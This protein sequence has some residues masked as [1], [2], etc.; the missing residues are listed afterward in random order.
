M[1]WRASEAVAGG[2]AAAGRVA[3]R[4][5]ALSYWFHLSYLSQ[6]VSVSGI[7]Q[8][9]GCATAMWSAGSCVAVLLLLPPR[10]PASTPA[11][12]PQGCNGKIYV[13]LSKSKKFNNKIFCFL[14]RIWHGFPPVSA[15]AAGT[16]F[17]R[18]SSFSNPGGRNAA[19]GCC[20][21][22]PDTA[23]Q[24]AA[25][26]YSKLKICASRLA[27]TS[28]LLHLF[29]DKQET[30]L[31][32]SPGSPD[33]TGASNVRGNPKIDTIYGNP[34][35]PSKTR[36]PS[37]TTAQ[38]FRAPPIRIK[39]PRKRRPVAG[40]RPLRPGPGRGRPGL[41]RSGPEQAEQQLWQPGEFTVMWR[42]ERRLL[43]PDTTCQ[44][45]AIATD[46]IFNNSLAGRDLLIK[47][48]FTEPWPGL[49]ELSVEVWHV[50]KPDK[51]ASTN[52]DGQKLTKI[53]LFL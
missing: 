23:G 8:R 46:V 16:L 33:R 12:A 36:I 5:A 41:G 34:K 42:Q 50:S 22:R 19:G 2:P 45:G 18:L 40:V 38:D 7:Q 20:A 37:K 29:R 26:C 51:V 47:L 35:A 3:A 49:F 15:Q 11:P 25:P 6:S 28:S 4:H 27:N 24:C 48:P 17:L 39:P 52:I 9:P 21:G 1:V 30:S 53:C 43:N 31:G 10:A 13:S 14:R 44:Y 32:R